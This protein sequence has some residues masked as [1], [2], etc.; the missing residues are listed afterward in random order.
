MSDRIVSPTQN[1]NAL[2]QPRIFAPDSCLDDCDKLK[3]VARRA[4]IEAI[5][6]KS[7]QFDVVCSGIGRFSCQAD[8]G[9]SAAYDE[10]LGT[11]IPVNDNFCLVGPNR[12]SIPG[13][14]QLS[15]ADLV[16][17]AIEKGITPV[18]AVEFVYRRH[19]PAR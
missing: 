11:P 13:A 2:R 15:P 3:K 7:A 9:Q 1:K 6:D 5:Q 4:M 8:M 10:D 17:A 16:N 12:D 18:M 14:D 19:D